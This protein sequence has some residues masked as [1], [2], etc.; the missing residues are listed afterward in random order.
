MVGGDSIKRHEG[1]SMTRI[2]YI[3]KIISNINFIAGDQNLSCV[4]ETIEL[5]KN[6]E[7]EVKAEFRRTIQV[8]EGTCHSYSNCEDCYPEYASEHI[9]SEMTSYI[10]GFIN[11]EY[12]S[13][14]RTETEEG[15]KKND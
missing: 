5:V 4:D 13:P 9:C 2:E 8:L 15:G 3:E 1:E 11:N 7:E 10:E 14:N 12:S 6:L